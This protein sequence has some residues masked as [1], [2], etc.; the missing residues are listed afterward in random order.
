MTQ[1]SYMG[2]NLPEYIEV[3]R[4]NGL[5]N[6]N[7][8]EFYMDVLEYYFE[9]YIKMLERLRL[10]DIS[11]SQRYATQLTSEGLI[12]W[13]GAYST[14]GERSFGKKIKVLHASVKYLSTED[15]IEKYVLPEKYPDTP[16]IMDRESEE[17]KKAV[18]TS[19]TTIRQQI[20]R[21][22][23]KYA[24]KLDERWYFPEFVRL[25]QAWVKPDIS[26]YQWDFIIVGDELEQMSWLDE[27]ELNGIKS[28]LYNSVAII[29][30][31]YHISEEFKK[32][33]KS[34]EKYTVDFFSIISSRIAV[35]HVTKKERDSLELFLIKN[36][37]V[38]YVF[39]AGEAWK[40]VT[41]AEK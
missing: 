33:L 22:K 37:F 20:K 19:V 5:K 13:L 41:E 32:N 2:L 7:R 36:P 40:N 8:K 15:Y 34:D 39:G 14:V 1:E 25:P 35:Y 18:N 23:I 31:L 26:R 12:L 27:R 11:D 30:G 28:G 4:K 9:Q 21:C 16:E 24:K 6:V 29:N 38:R 17:H 10:P 3:V